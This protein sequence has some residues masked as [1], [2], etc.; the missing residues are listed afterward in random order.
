MEE[1]D[2]T[3]RAGTARFSVEVNIYDNQG[4]ITKDVDCLVHYTRTT[5]TNGFSITQIYVGGIRLVQQEVDPTPWS[6][7]YNTWYSSM[8][9]LLEVII[10]RVHFNTMSSKFFKM[11]PQMAL[12]EKLH[13]QD[14]LNKRKRG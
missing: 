1:N 8:H 4:P 3:R 11:T 5:N 10:G 14:M 7:N 12:S 9:S 2:S 6:N 13:K